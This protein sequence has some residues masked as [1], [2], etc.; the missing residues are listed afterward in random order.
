MEIGDVCRQEIFLG[1]TRWLCNFHFCLHLHFSIVIY[2]FC[3]F[4]V[5]DFHIGLVTVFDA[6]L[7]RSR[8]TQ[9]EYSS[10]PLKLSIVK[11]ILV[12]KQ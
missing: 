11:L 12:F 4:F 5:L 2:I 9:Q 3:A 8:G 1:N 6:I 10:K 7:T